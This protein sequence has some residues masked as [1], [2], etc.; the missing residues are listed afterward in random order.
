MEKKDTKKELENQKIL[1]KILVCGYILIA[2]VSLNLILTIAKMDSVSTTESKFDI[3]QFKTIEAKNLKNELNT[4]DKAVL[5]IGKEDCVYT[6]KMIPI[7]KRAQE[8]YGY[9][10]L[11][12]DFNE[13]SDEDKDAILE[14]DD[15][16]NVLEENYGSTPTIIVFEDKKMK[17]LWIGYESYDQFASFLEE[18]GFDKK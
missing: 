14:Y 3:S 18:L 17:D 8:E 4:K 2:L 9:K 11:Y 10:T 12:L 5:L 16:T 13:L 6:E 15:D 1:K 7:L